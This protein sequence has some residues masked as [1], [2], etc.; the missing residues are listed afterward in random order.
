M[1]Y[2]GRTGAGAGGDFRD[3]REERGR[4]MTTLILASTSV[5][6]KA[7]LERLGLAIE[8][9]APGV[10]EA[11]YQTKTM[12]PKQL[13]EELASAK[14][15]AVAVRNPG[16]IIIGGDQLLSFEGQVLGKPGTF[17]NAVA[18]LM[19]L[20]GRTHELVTAMSVISPDG[21]EHRHTDVS[22]MTMRTL[23]RERIERYVRLDMPLDC[24]GSYKIES[25]GIALFAAISSADQSAITGLPLMALTAILERLGVTVPGDFE[26]SSK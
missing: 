26:K 15:R 21:V 6:R 18:Q 8:C 23:D 17:E 3:G 10:D 19:R 5:Y 22:C 11:S 25:G 16:R 12:A 13:A 14:A 24:A 9:I 7:L 1:S 20:S 2:P 4:A